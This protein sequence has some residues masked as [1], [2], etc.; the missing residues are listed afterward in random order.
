MGKKFKRFIRHMF[1][2]IW[3][4]ELFICGVV[5][6]V[7]GILFLHYRPDSFLPSPELA[8]YLASL[9]YPIEAIFMFLIFIG[10]AAG[11]LVFWIVHIWV[12]LLDVCLYAFLKRKKGP[13]AVKDNVLILSVDDILYVRL[14]LMAAEYDMGLNQFCV[15][16]LDSVSPFDLSDEMFCVCDEEA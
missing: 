13:D 9:P 5:V 14:S 10:V 16:V 11:L 7:L 4:G 8:N 15:S 6:V 2:P 12:A 1:R 3:A